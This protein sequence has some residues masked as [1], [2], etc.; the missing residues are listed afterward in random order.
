MKV[1][2]ILSNVL[3]FNRKFDEINYSR[4]V[5]AIEIKML[6]SEFLT[7]LEHI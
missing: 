5:I 4:N 6:I 7:K 1:S 2:L 3:E